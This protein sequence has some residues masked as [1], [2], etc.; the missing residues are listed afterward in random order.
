M[1]NALLTGIFNLIIGLVNALLS[2]IDALIE[3]F[4]PD[5]ATGLSYIS[6][7]FNYIGNFISYILSWFHLP[8]QFIT[9]IV[10]YWTFKL[11]VPLLVHTVKLAISWYDKLKP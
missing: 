1:I 9:L 5:L 11:T 10:A 3:Q 6:N 2:P 8:T 7:F 4:I